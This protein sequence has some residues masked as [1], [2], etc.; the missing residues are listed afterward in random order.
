MCR[1]KTDLKWDDRLDAVPPLAGALIAFV[2]LLIVLA[3][4]AR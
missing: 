3:I 4:T 2:S 1:L